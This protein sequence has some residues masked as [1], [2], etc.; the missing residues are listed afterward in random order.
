M[1]NLLINKALESLN[2]DRNKYADR[3]LLQCVRRITPEII[4]TEG[5]HLIGGEV[6]E[7][8]LK[9]MRKRAHLHLGRNRS[10][11]LLYEQ[12]ILEYLINWIPKYEQQTLEYLIDFIPNKDPEYRACE[13][14]LIEQA[15]GNHEEVTRLL[16]KLQKEYRACGVML[17]EQ[18][19]GNYEEVT[20][21]LEK[22]QKDRINRI[23][24]D[25]RRKASSPRPISPLDK[26]IIEIVKGNPQITV[27]ELIKE[28]N[29][30]H[31]DIK[32]TVE[33][34]QIQV[35]IPN[36]DLSKEYCKTYAKSGMR[37]RLSRIKKV[38]NKKNS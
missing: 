36:K 8:Y 20:R 7:L 2:L 18:A 33:D 5:F 23:S 37:S 13:V 28:L 19:N 16:E 1:D 9:V 10:E 35:D 17:I 6:V 26:R 27:K 38:I 21:L 3:A 29:K 32:I 11:S 12:Q 15:N 4:E 30:Y 24:I 14:M 22:L 34:D 31:L 25:Q